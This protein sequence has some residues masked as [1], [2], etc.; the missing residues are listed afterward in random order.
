M[1]EVPLVIHFSREPRFKL[2]VEKHFSFS[3][4]LNCRDDI[5]DCV[6]LTLRTFKQRYIG[7]SADRDA[8]HGYNNQNEMHRTQMFDVDLGPVH[9]SGGFSPQKGHETPLTASSICKREVI[10]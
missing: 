9:V 3:V 1:S 4:Y 2:I 8:G 6:N 5:Y 7:A 10:V